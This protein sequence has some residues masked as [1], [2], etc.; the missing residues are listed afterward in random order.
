MRLNRVLAT[1]LSSL[2]FAILFGCSSAPTSSATSVSNTTPSMSVP[3][4]MIATERS[5]ELNP[6]RWV[7]GKYEVGVCNIRDAQKATRAY[8]RTI[9]P[10]FRKGKPE[11]E[12]QF[13]Q[14]DAMDEVGDVTFPLGSGTRK[15]MG[16]DG[17]ESWTTEMTE[18]IILSHFIFD[19]KGSKMWPDL[20][21][22]TTTKVTR[23]LQS[24]TV[25]LELTHHGKPMQTCT[26]KSLAD[27]SDESSVA[28]VR[29]LKN[30]ILELFAKVATSS[31]A[32]GVDLDQASLHN[33]RMRF[34]TKN[35]TNDQIKEALR[36]HAIG[37]RVGE[38]KLKPVSSKADPAKTAKAALKT[39]LGVVDGEDEKSKEDFKAVTEFAKTVENFLKNHGAKFKIHFVE[40]NESDADGEGLFIIDSANGQ[41]F[42][43]GS[44]YYS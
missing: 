33:A 17:N 7:V 8:V 21:M 5:K 44:G 26:L 18:T 13:Y 34:E 9:R 41:A 16:T 15:A 14:K 35:A 1:A 27:Q 20:H 23:E 10:K 37:M 39:I 29:R 24:K 6:I 25:Q 11:L 22:E 3:S 30:P 4:R 42:Y 19:R 2:S 38:I 12:I 31:W 36:L 28:K 40:W 43:V 32:D